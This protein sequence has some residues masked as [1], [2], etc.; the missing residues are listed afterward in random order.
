MKAYRKRLTYEDK[1]DRNYSCW[2]LNH[3]GWSKCKTHNRRKAR[4]KIK[5]ET[6]KEV[7]I[8]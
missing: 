5:I 2:C 3:N 4:R 1:F 6:M 8:A 7:E